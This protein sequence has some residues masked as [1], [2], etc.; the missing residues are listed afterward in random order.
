MILDPANNSPLAQRITLGSPAV[1]EPERSIASVTR[2]LT[3]SDTTE[4]DADNYSCIATNIAE[5][6]RDEEGF[7]LFV[8]GKCNGY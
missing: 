3:I 8:Q 2:T 6:G 7:E 4:G 1:D 5:G